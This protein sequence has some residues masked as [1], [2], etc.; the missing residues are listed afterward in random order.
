MMN[1]F[2]YG[3]LFL[4]LLLYVDRIKLLS[5]HRRI[6]TERH[7]DCQWDFCIIRCFWE[8]FVSPCEIKTYNESIRSE[9][10]VWSS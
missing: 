10:V 9:R 8:M 4:I 1:D 2:Q 5:F 7:V 6:I 3:R